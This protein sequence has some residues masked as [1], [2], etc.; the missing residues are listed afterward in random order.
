MKRPWPTRIVITVD[1]AN[2]VLET[3]GNLPYTGIYA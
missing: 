2:V 1:V 3:N